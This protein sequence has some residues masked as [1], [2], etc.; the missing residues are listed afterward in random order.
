MTATND[1]FEGSDALAGVLLDAIDL[2]LLDDS[3][4]VRVSDVACSLA[5]EHWHA[6][7][8]LLQA[9]LLPSATVLHRSQFEALTRSIWLAYVAS[10]A[11]VSKLSAPLAPVSEQAAKNMPLVA[12]MMRGIEASAPAQAY[13]ALLRFKENSWPALNSYAH[14][15]IHPIRRHHDGYPSSLIHDMLRNANGLAV[16]S[17]MQAVVLSGEQPLQRKVLEIAG[18]FPHCMPAPL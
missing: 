8:A 9:S 7:R 10:D 5:L 3:L 18:R 12:E 1:I 14:A 6:V 11:H 15:G 16:M 17:C 13:E 4:R 2:P